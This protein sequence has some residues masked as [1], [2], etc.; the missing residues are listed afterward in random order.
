MKQKDNEKKKR[1]KRKVLKIVSFKNA[2][3]QY[4]YIYT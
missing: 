3:I 4:E 1:K 2:G